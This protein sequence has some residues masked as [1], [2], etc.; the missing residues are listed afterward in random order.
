[1]A[2]KNKTH[3][4]SLFSCL[5]FIP[6]LLWSQ[7]VSTAIIFN[8]TVD[9]KQYNH[10]ELKNAVQSMDL[11]TA[12]NANG[13]LSNKNLK[14]TVAFFDR[15]YV[16]NMKL[17]N[18]HVLTTENYKMQW[19]ERTKNNSEILFLFVKESGKSTYEF[20]DMS[21]SDL[22]SN[23]HLFKEV[24]AFINEHLEGTP[25]NIVKNGTKYL[26]RALTPVW[27]DTKRQA[28]ENLIT[29]PRYHADMINFFHGT[30]LSTFLDIRPISLLSNY[31]SHLA[32]VYLYNN[33]DTI[34]P[35]ILLHADT[36]IFKGNTISVSGDGY[37]FEFIPKMITVNKERILLLQIKKNTN[38]EHQDYI[39]PLVTALQESK[40]YSTSKKVS[41]WE[42]NKSSNGIF[43]LN[44]TVGLIDIKADDKFELIKVDMNATYSEGAKIPVIHPW[45]PR[46]FCNVYA[47][48]LAR[49]ILFPNTF[50]AGN[51]KSGSNEYA[52]WGKHDSAAKLHE[53]IINNIN[54]H[55][56]PVTFDEA[57]KYTNA[58]YVVYLTAYN[59]RY[60]TGETNNP[61]LRS[62][63][64]ATCYETK[65]YTEYSKA[66]I[67]QAGGGNN[68][69]VITFS[70]G[71]GTTGY[72]N[73]HEEIKANLYLGYILK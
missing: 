63:H 65:E 17:K 20:T 64:I 1:M 70:G 36:T 5:I 24:V 21:V 51:D 49:W 33:K 54:G 27:T 9:I 68:S 60:Y 19:K 66:Q 34:K 16:G 52:P 55:F 39:I 4:L 58:G 29:Y 3:I 25:V 15:M 38:N 72:G 30:W 50:V 69:K 13:H 7:K 53:A 56:K 43:S 2:M 61:Y 11:Q 59:R 18:P 73:N 8:N 6:Q 32:K 12:L 28:A 37:F 67:I 42:W 31:S 14:L 45:Y 22:L 71:W 41:E 35:T 46:T 48:D 26:A 23:E 10:E 40:K 57:W 62:G 44:S 47:S